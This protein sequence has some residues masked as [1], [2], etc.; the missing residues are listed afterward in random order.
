[1]L[2]KSA[3]KRLFRSS[4][5][6][7]RPVASLDV[8]DHYVFEIGRDRRTAQRHR[9]LAVN[10][11]RCGGLLAGAGQRDADIGMLGLARAVHDAAHYGDVEGFDARIARLPFRHGDMNEILDFAG[12]LLE[13]GGGRAPAARACRDQRYKHAKAHG[14]KEFLGDLDL[15]RAVAAGFRRQRNA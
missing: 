10:E 9:L 14:L 1:M 11:Y 3:L 5:A 15:K 2:W 13:R 6:A 12:K 4:S 8:I 7:A